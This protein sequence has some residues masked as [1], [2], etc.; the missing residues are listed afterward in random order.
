MINYIQARIFYLRGGGSAF[1]KTLD[2]VDIGIL[3]PMCALS[4]RV[5]WNKAV[6]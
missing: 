6:L 1:L 5:G 4:Y 3:I 2:D